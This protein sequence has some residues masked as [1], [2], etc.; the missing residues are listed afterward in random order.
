[1]KYFR[2]YFGY[3]KDDFYSIEEKELPKAIK[4]QITG[5]VALLSVA[6]ISGNEIKRIQPDYQRDM[7]WN[8]DYQLGA[9]D[10]LQIG[11]KKRKEYEDTYLL[12]KTN[13]ERVLNNLPPVANIEVSTEAKMLAEKYKI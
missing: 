3:G 6:T 2:V 8:R 1:M 10:Y 11:S 7:G 4:A 13:T 12:I 9:E 5:Q